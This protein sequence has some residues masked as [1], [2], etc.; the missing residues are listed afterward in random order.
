MVKIQNYEFGIMN[1]LS[2]ARRLLSF[3][4]RGFSQWTTDY[5]PRTPFLRSLFLFLLC[6]FI[7]H[8]SA[9]PQ[10][11][12]AQ[13]GQAIFPVNAKFVQ[14]NGPGYW[15]TAG[16]NLTLNLAPGTAVCSNTVQTYA[17]GTLT[18]APSATNYVYLD[19][20]N[21]CAPA[22][23][24]TGFT[25]AS[26][27]IA[28]VVTSSTA[29]SAIT[30]VRTMFVWGGGGAN[31]TLSNLVGPTNI[32]TPSLTFAGAAGIT[33]G[34]TN[35]NA[36][37]TPSGT[38]L[39]LVTN[40][41]DKGGQV[42]NVKGYGCYGD[43]VHDD[44]ACIQSVLNLFT[45]GRAAT[46]SGNIFF[47]PG[48]YKI[49]SPLYYVGGSGYSI[50]ISGAT[51]AVTDA[52][53]TLWWGG[54]VGSTMFETLAANNFVFEN[55]TFDQAGSA[56]VGIQVASDN[57]INT[58]LGT[59]VTSGSQ[60]VT[61]GSM[62]GIAVG[63]LLSI[64]ASPNV[65]L[66]YVTAITGTTFTATFTKS[67]ASTAQVGGT[68]GSANGQ[69][70]NVNVINVPTSSTDWVTNPVIAT[71][72]MVFGNLI[73]TNTPEV[74]D[75]SISNPNIVCNL[76]CSAGI[77]FVDGGNVKDFWLYNI[78][79]IDAQFGIDAGNGG[80]GLINILNGSEGN[81]T[82]A[83]IRLSAA[84]AFISG[85]EN[86]ANTGHLFLSCSNSSNVTLS[87]NSWQ[88][89]APS[90]D[91][92]IW[93]TG[94]LNMLGNQFWNSRTSSSIAKVVIG[95]P[96]FNNSAGA[97]VTS[98]GNYYSNTPAGYAPFY[99]GNGNQVLPTYYANQAVMVTSIGDSGGYPGTPGLITLQNYFTASAITSQV[100][101]R[102]GAAT[103]GVVRAGNVDTAVAF[104]NNAATGNVNGLSKGTND[105]VQ[106]GDVA[107]AVA[108]G[109]FTA[110]NLTNTSTTQYG[111]L[112]GG[113]SSSPEKSTAAGTSGLPLLGQ[114]SGSAPAFGTLGIAGGGTGQTSASAAFNTLSPLSTEGD[115][116]YYHSS[117]NARLGVGGNGQ[118]LVSNGTDPVWGSC[119]GS[120]SLAWSSLVNPVASLTLPMFTYATTF[121]HTSPVNWTWANTTAATSS[122]GQLS[123][124]LNLSGT[125][126]NGSASA[127]DSWSLQDVVAGGTNGNSTFTLAHTGS[128]GTATLSVPNLTVTSTNQYGVLYGGGSSA[129]VNST[130]A[131][132]IGFPL[133]GQGSAAPTFG[134]LGI[135]G[136]GTGQTTASSAFNALSPLTTEGDLHYYHSSSNARLGIGSN[137]QCLTSNGTDPV[138]GSCSTGS[139]TVTSVGLSMPSLFSVSGS[140]VTG[141]GTLTATLANQNP[142]LILAGPSSGGAAAPTF[143]ALGGADLP[144]PTAS[145]LGGVESISCTTGQ[146]LNQISTAGTP[147]CGTPTGGWSGLGNGTTVIDASLQAGTDFGSKVNAAAQLCPSAGCTIDARG[148]ASPQTMSV[149]IT[150]PA[151][152]VLWLPA[153]TINRSKGV[154]FILNNGDHVRGDSYY[155]TDIESTDISDDYSP[156][157]Y[158]SAQLS[159]VEID[160]LKIG[161]TTPSG[162]ALA[163]TSVANASGGNTVYTGTI[164]GGGSNAYVGM[165]FG[166]FGNFNGMLNEGYYICTASTTTTLTL[167]NPNGTA[168][169]AT[170][171]AVRSGGWGIS[172][173][174]G[175]S[176]IHDILM[177]QTD[178][179]IKFAD[180]GC[181]CYNR[182]WNLILETKH[183]GMF[184]GEDANSNYGWGVLAW[185]SDQA[186]A[187]FANATGYAI[188]FRGAALNQIDGLDIENTKYSIDINQ[189]YSN[190]LS[191]IYWENDYLVGQNM[192]ALVSLPTLRNGTLNN[193]IDSALDVVDTSGNHTNMYGTQHSRNPTVNPPS[194]VSLIGVPNPS[195]YSAGVI[196]GGGSTVT[197]YFE[198][199]EDWNGNRTIPYEMDVTGGTPGPYSLTLTAANPSGS[200]TVYTG[201]IT[202]GANNGLVN[203]SNILFTVTGFTNSGNNGTFTIAAST[204][205][206]LT[207]NNPSGVAETNAGSAA[208]TA[209]NY[210]GV[211]EGGP[212]VKCYDILKGATNQSLATCVPSDV[213]PVWDNGSVTPLAYTPPTRNSTA[214]AYFGGMLTTANNTLDDGKGN[215]TAANQMTAQQF[216]I[217][218]SCI[219]TWPTV[220]SLPLSIA[221]GGTGNISGNV[222]TATALAAT[223]AQCPGSQFAVGIAANGNAN[224]A[225][226]SGSGGGS[227]TFQVDGTITSNQS[228][229]N[230]INGTF[231]T[232]SNPSAGQ[233]KFDITS[234][235]APTSST[236]GGIQSIGQNANNWIQYIDTSGIPH[237]AQPGFSN[238]SGSLAAGQTPLTTSQDILFMSGVALGRLPISTVTSGQCLGNN[239]GTW[240]S[241]ACNSGS[242]VTFE[243]NGS[244]TSNQTTINFTNGTYLTASNPSAGQV[245]FDITSLPS[246][247]A[248]TLGGI[249]SLAAVG[250]KWI[251]AISTGGV[252]SATQPASSDLSDYGSF[253][254]AAFGSQSGNL[255]YAAP[256]GSSGNPSFR[257]IVAADVPSALS[258]T[259][260]VN[261][262]TIPSGGVAL[263]QTIASGT[264]SLGTSSISSGA[265]APVVTAT[266]TNVATTDV[267]MAGFNG[268]PTSTTGYVPSTSGMLTI[269]AYPT[270]GNVNFKVCNNTDA[271]ITPGSV[272]LNW[273]VTR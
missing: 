73:S 124:L 262:T 87:G 110:P 126:W 14:G 106:V 152:V 77:A 178:L 187:G 102:S 62:S 265:C 24:L 171:T 61:P 248:S 49:T 227:A 35:Q 23:N 121:N 225:T 260:S 57:T 209:I 205:T 138:W 98:I 157:F 204:A 44:T 219:T 99:D 153:A 5:R 83:D 135:A 237:L 186:T 258:S 20:S 230:F 139:G 13:A 198:V 243:V 247:T 1:C 120:S 192:A 29:I 50:R 245:N 55:L 263:T 273:R 94:Q 53:S 92:V 224:C 233:V 211:A 104:L 151:N 6:Q 125:Y 256:N 109:P 66:V 19:S 3:A 269:I 114:G 17:G 131:G 118:C 40:L 238:L 202:G 167:A 136:G 148:F 95:G 259:T 231:L 129:I 18:L 147:S 207:L 252:P 268:D 70:N 80:V 34:G 250:H 59:A 141:S 137:G 190:T 93:C 47:P 216:C 25:S 217:T 105:V 123:P 134:T 244:N 115:F 197:K 27:P 56:R 173:S 11:P 96:L 161:A 97:S 156:I 67:H 177:Y 214:D 241:I 65:E 39:G 194:S 188:R 150:L 195:I 169:T 15:P 46:A 128:P 42:Y 240:G 270:S 226:P 145:A 212:G 144:T 168:E 60:T 251:N 239:S 26:I 261:G 264:A 182:F 85:L 133:L 206:T 63:S 193:K 242:P 249:E 82:V 54:P 84:T 32:S 172:N 199:I 183:G 253:P 88:S 81:T 210:I 189:G 30:D 257:A 101:G 116:L 140:P 132:A 74:G 111:V 208:S 52:G 31:T 158:G 200:T 107:G 154:Q 10:Q 16:S 165:E 130:A 255:F 235:P 254:G 7:I 179:G 218:T 38:G 122:T 71:A 112:Y 246:P 75:I 103:T 33:A 266:A 272:T 9:F 163:I 149:S 48:I 64:D 21:N 191:N 213:M 160:H 201:T 196:A 236:L 76:G 181:T 229:I 221:N 86:E 166:V 58:T 223:P 203:T 174:F 89:P 117:A 162:S 220:P 170:G 41:A 146:F 228:V 159:N 232:A 43:G 51:S 100:N 164:T 119:S 68:A 2:I 215:V 12:Q 28:T 175:N 4:V 45:N 155:A 113:G 78:D 176:H 37:L 271:A 184:F 222:P 72:G 22:S 69:V 91:Y 143:R 180:S 127:T 90:N 234:L 36:D 108:T 185:A 79:I 142:H 8:N 267:V